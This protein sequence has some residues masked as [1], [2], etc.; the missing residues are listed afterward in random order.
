MS[1]PTTSIDDLPP[2]MINELFEYLP[3]KDLATCSLVNRRWHSIYASF[4]LHRLATYCNDDRDLNRWLNSN[5]PIEEAERCHPKM[6]LRLA[7][8]PLLSNLTH[9]ALTG[10]SFEYDLNKLNQFPQLV[11]LEINISVARNMQ[12]NMQLNLPILKVLAI[13]GWT[14]YRLTVDCPQLSTL[15]YQAEMRRLVV[16]H[17]ETI[18]KL[19]TNLIGPDLYQF[20]NV[21]SLVTNQFE[22]I[23]LITISSLPRLRELHYNQ[24]IENLI[25]RR[26]VDAQRITVDRLKRTLSELLDEAKRLRGSDFRFTLAGFQLTQV[27]MEQIDFGV[28]VDEDRSERVYN[29]YVYLKNYH[30]IEPDSLPFVYRV[31]YNR[32]LNSLT[33][34]FPR[35]FSQK[36]TGINWVETTAEVQNADHLLWFLKSLRFL[37]RLYLETKGLSQEFYDQLPASTR[38]LISLTL[39]GGNELQ[40]NFDFINKLPFLKSHKVVPPISFGS[41]TSLFGCIGNL[42]EGQFEV[43]LKG[44]YFLIRK[45]TTE[46]KV[47]KRIPGDSARPLEMFITKKPEEMADFF[48]HLQAWTSSGGIWIFSIFFVF[49][50][51]FL[52]AV[53]WINIFLQMAK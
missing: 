40:L 7:E 29:E 27:D 38:S 10:N 2:E 52:L 16:K 47:L 18:R 3:P 51:L 48:K 4:K 35:C 50:F 8:K 33:G 5:Q 45:Q 12:R 37:R 17:P 13:H 39:E 32:L 49:L 24:G 11:H 14:I 21:E 9:L 36:F 42:M 30:L 34:E 46:W 43:Q 28:Q 19:Q 44:E 20:K 6:F 23:S 1:P 31:D 41:L 22:A 25:G 15:L 53:L 26:F